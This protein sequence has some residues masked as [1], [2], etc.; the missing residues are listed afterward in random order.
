MIVAEEIPGVGAPKEKPA[1]CQPGRS[2][3]ALRQKDRKRD[4]ALESPRVGAPKEQLLQ[5]DSKLSGQGDRADTALVVDALFFAVFLESFVC[6]APAAGNVEAGESMAFLILTNNDDVVSQFPLATRIDGEAL[7]VI[8]K[9]RDLIH[10]GHPLLAHPLMGSV[11]PNQ[12]PYKTI[13]LDTK[14]GELDLQSLRLIEGTIA[15]YEKFLR[16]HPLPEWDER[17]LADLRLVDL[18]LAKNT[19]VQS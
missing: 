15:T 4:G 7:D 14:R 10:L 1:A 5:T 16:D 18:L 19:L 13:I 8:R 9:A 17:R 12:N 11:K 3:E 2:R 6:P